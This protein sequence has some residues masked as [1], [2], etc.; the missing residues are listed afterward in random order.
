MPLVSSAGADIW[1]EEA[2]R[3]DGPP[4]LLL[5]GLG[6]DHVP[7][8]RHVPVLG[9]D[10]RLILVDNRGVGRSGKP[11]GPYSIEQMAK[12]ALAVLV[13][14]GVARAHV[15]GIS[16]GGM[17]AQELVLAAPE[18]VDR[19]VLACTA[20]RPRDQQAAGVGPAA[21]S[22]LPLVDLMK[23]LTGLCFS[24][25]F[26]RR[27]R[28]YLKQLFAGVVTW[29]DPRAFF[30]QLE[31]IQAHDTV[32]RLHAIAA[33]T[34]VL[35]GDCDRMVPPAHSDVLLRG[36][37]GAR[38]SV[39]QGGSHGFHLEQSEWFNRAVLDFLRA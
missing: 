14:A 37:P 13:A 16:M 20:A 6:T 33:P 3:P 22:E 26:V 24:D 8:L 15:V 2:G 4:V 28:A 21:I 1:Y 36:I 27:E 31:A 9:R 32:A 17:I 29:F 11:P 30:A 23:T 5:Q 10:F 39:L 12:D 19:L 7:W 38:L 18:R 35:T 25:E 34:L